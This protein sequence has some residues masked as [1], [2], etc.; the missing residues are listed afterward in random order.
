MFRTGLKSLV[1]VVLML[2]ALALLVTG[3]FAQGPQPQSGTASA[4]YV[5]SDTCKGCHEEVHKAFEP[6]AH[7]QL[8]GGDKNKPVKADWHGCESCHGPGSAHVEGGGDKTKIIRFQDLSAKQAS[9]RCLQCHQA[10]HEQNN[11]ARSAHLANDVG[12]TSCHSVH[13]AKEKHALLKA[14]QPALCYDCHTETRAEFSRPF[15]HRVN[16]GLV[17]CVDCHNVHGG[18]QQ[19]QLHASAAQDQVCFKCHTEKKGPFVYEHMPVK[20]EGC[21]SCHTPHGSTNPR[22]MRVSSV[23]LLCLQCH[24]LAQSNI[25]SQPPI[26]PAH[27][28]AQKYQACTMCHNS[29]H[30]S[31]FSEVFFKP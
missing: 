25:P 13:A 31:N 19:R 24:T 20:T 27:N 22:L 15:R 3:A 23:N 26:G 28:Q 5:G 9:E 29:I 7:F 14:S 11:F 16:E 10:G 12:C 6:T 21:S 18:F 30:G 8:L 1:F 4:Q 17:K 2:L